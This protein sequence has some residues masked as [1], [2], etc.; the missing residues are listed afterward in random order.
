MEKDRVCV[1]VCGAVYTFCVLCITSSH[2]LLNKSVEDENHFNS[3]ELLSIVNT[4]GKSEAL[5][6]KSGNGLVVAFN[7]A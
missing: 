1:C 6:G 2:L 4:P 7:S 3:Y 5:D